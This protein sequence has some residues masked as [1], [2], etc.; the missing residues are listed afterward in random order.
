MD[1]KLKRKTF[2]EKTNCFLSVVVPCHNES[3][4]LPILCPRLEKVLITNLKEDWEV[5]LVDDSS[6]DNS[7]EIIQRFHYRNC[8]FKVIRMEKRG[9]QTGAYREA[10]KIARGKYILRMDC[11]L[12]DNPQELP[13]FIEKMKKDYDV[14]VGIREGIKNLRAYRL[15]SCAY[16]FVS[17]LFFG[18]PFHEAS[19][20]YVGFKARYLKDLKLWNNDHRYLV[21]IALQRGIEKP[22]EVITR[23]GMRKGG[24]SKYNPFI[25]LVFG[26]PEIFLFVIRAKLGFYN[27]KNG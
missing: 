7:Y 9:G 12:Q 18:S 24:K 4:S 15:A 6:T 13:L 25:K 3:D 8:N 14:I 10:F 5:L 17:I 26:F 20:S 16:N 23:H 1:S 27:Y 11:D 2:S 19:S 21:S 22:A